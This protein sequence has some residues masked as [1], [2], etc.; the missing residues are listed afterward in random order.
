MN[1][2][3]ELNPRE[4]KIPNRVKKTRFLICVCTARPGDLK[5]QKMMSN[6][7]RVLGDRQAP[8]PVREA[9]HNFET[10]IWI[11]SSRICHL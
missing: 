7:G 8:D 4:T 11:L 9:N 2:V 10:C 5:V 1:N 6:T 3:G